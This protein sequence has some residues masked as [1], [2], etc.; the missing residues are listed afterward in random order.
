MYGYVAVGSDTTTV[1]GFA[2]YAQGETPG[3]GGEVDNPK[4]KQQWIGKKLFN[5]A[6]EVIF[7]VAK[8]QAVGNSQ[9]DGLSGAT[10]TGRGVTTSTKYW[11][12]T[13]GYQ[14]FLAKVKAGE[15]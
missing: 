10:I 1:K 14:A 11:F 13:H 7:K 4:W 12:G 6:G 5:D 2:Y 9:V 15:I 3:L 8:G